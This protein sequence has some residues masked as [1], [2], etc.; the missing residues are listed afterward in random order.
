MNL[1]TLTAVAAQFANDSAQSRYSGLYTQALNL[2]QQQFV[3]D[4]KCL[5]KDAPTVSI[6]AGTANYSLPTDF[7]WEKQVNLNGLML[8]PISRFELARTNTGSR[9]DTRTGTPRNYNI[10][11]DVSKSQILLFPIPEANDAGHDLI[12]T[13]YAMPTDMAA[14]TDIPLNSTPLLAQFH[15]GLAA[16]A[17]WYLLHGDDSTPEMTAK[18]RELLAIYNDCV[19]QCVDTFKNTVSQPIRMRGVRNYV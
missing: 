7:L 4:T 15:V 1:S 19:S 17:A 11:P 9:W 14:A 16:W 6:V 10:D 13:Y 2:A 8:T 5:W 12:L 18:K 3:L